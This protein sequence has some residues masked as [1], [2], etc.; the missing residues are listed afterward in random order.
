LLTPLAFSQQTKMLAPI[1]ARNTNPRIV[2]TYRLNFDNTEGYDAHLDVEGDGARWRVIKFYQIPTDL[3]IKV[4]GQPLGYINGEGIVENRW[5]PFTK[6]LPLIINIPKSARFPSTLIYE[7]NFIRDPQAGMKPEEA[8]EQVKLEGNIDDKQPPLQISFQSDTPNLT[9]APTET[10]AETQTASQSPAASNSPAVDKEDTFNKLWLLIAVPLGIGAVA[11]LV[12]LAR[13][14]SGPRGPDRRPSRP[15]PLSMDYDKLGGSKSIKSNVTGQDITSYEKEKRS[16]FLG[17][18]RKRREEPSHGGDMFAS[19]TTNLS[20]APATGQQGNAMSAQPI[21]PVQS[22]AQPTEMPPTPLV[23]SDTAT[24]RMPTGQPVDQPGAGTSREAQRLS[25]ETEGRLSGHASEIGKLKFANQ[26]L[27]TKV[28]GLKAQLDAQKGLRDELQ[29]MLDELKN[30][31]TRRFSQD[32]DVVVRQLAEYRE[33][34]QQQIA[35]AQRSAENV[36]ENMKAYVGQFEEKARSQAAEFEQ[37]KK[38]QHDSYSRLLGGVLGLNVETLRE[39]PFDEVVKEAGQNLDRFFQEQVPSADGL[40]ELQQKAE[41]ISSVLE[42]TVG[43]MRDIKPDMDKLQHYVDHA[44]SLASDLARVSSQLQSR[45][46]NFQMTLSVPVEARQ[47]AREGFLDELGKAVKR[48]MDKLSDPRQHWS[49]EIDQLVTTKIVA[50][51]DICDKEVIGYP[52]A[53]NELEQSLGELFRQAGL[54]SVVPKQGTEFKP[55]EQHLVQMVA[56][57]PADSQKVK[58]VVRR[59]FYYNA[60]G[61]EELIRKAGVEIYR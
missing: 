38:Q 45:Q 30:E 40:P 28:D 33:E 39:G 29:T 54:R 14:M 9:P 61:K 2:P 32:L 12:W 34:H 56:G 37:Q 43:K 36:L 27:E 25:Q 24:Q 58:R 7:L 35:G 50:V 49:K 41:A 21:P 26:T 19:E 10:R 3:K 22:P 42:T 31:L 8:R 52:G 44:K 47:G 11:L 53:N 6:R 1:D 15:R 18:G 46:L 48:E 17:F 60:N 13:K 51:T 23:T 20:G 4:D 5:Y 55:A 16:S 57:S 59:G